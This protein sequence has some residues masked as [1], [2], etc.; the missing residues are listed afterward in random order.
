MTTQ[1]QTFTATVRCFT[2]DTDDAEQGAAYAQLAERLKTDGRGKIMD[3]FGSA[4][5]GRPFDGQTVTL[6]AAH[7]FD[8]QWNTA[9]GVRLFDW[10]EMPRFNDRRTSLPMGGVPLNR[11]TGYYLELGDDALQARRDR[12]ACGYC[13]KQTLAPPADGFCDK[14][15]G[16]PHLKAEDLRLLRLRPVWVSFGTSRPP[17]TDAE[18]DALLPRMAEAQTKV[19][20]AAQKA[21]AVKKRAEVLAKFEKTTADAKTERDSFIFLLDHGV[22]LDNV[23]FYPHTQR[24]S[25]GWRGPLSDGAVGKLLE[26]ISDFPGSY[27]IATDPAGFHQGRTLSGN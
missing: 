13:G 1:P 19:A 2:F 14:C 6:E 26:I 10:A 12:L 25:F 7:L 24:F 21:A 23:I 18:R 9:E 15:L 3:A 11:R 5:P 20:S 27:D 17:L 22:P 16:S 8:N 4:E